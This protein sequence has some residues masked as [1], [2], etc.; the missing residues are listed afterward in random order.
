MNTWVW[1]RQLC[2]IS[3]IMGALTGCDFPAG[4]RPT[5]TPAAAVSRGGPQG[6]GNSGNS[7]NSDNSAAHPVA[8]KSQATPIP[9]TL[10]TTLTPT[11]TLEATGQP[12]GPY[13]VRQ[14]MTQGHI[15]LHSPPEGVCVNKLWRVPASAP[16]VPSILFVFDPHGVYPGIN[17]NT[18]GY[19]YNIPRAGESH[20]AQGSYKL[21][22]NT[23]GSLKVSLTARD[24]VVFKG[25]DGMMPVQFTF[26]LVP[27]SGNATCPNP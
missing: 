6:V 23:D 3:L 9:P 17:G 13:S 10:T 4:G 1:I 11:A 24:H 8:P 25:F 14:T 15:T 2:A 16:E 5:A 19:A 20:Q 21:T 27:M 12:V 26:D 18:F 22:S 7:A